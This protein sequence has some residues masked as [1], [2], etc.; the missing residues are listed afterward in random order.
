MIVD[1]GALIGP[2]PYGDLEHTADDLLR[3][4]D[5]VGI[6]QAWVGHLSS[7]LYKE[8]ATANR[9]LA[10][11]LKVHGDR[12]RPVP[13]VHPGL[14]DWERDLRDAQEMG[15]VAVRVYPMHQSLSPD[16]SEM[17]ALVHGAAHVRLP[18]ILTVRFEDVRQRHP[19]DVAADLPPSAVR[20]LARVDAEARLLVCH[21]GR[22]FVQEVHFGLTPEEAAR[23]L[24]DVSWIWGPPEDDLALLL[25]TIGSKS[26]AFGTGA[27]LRIPES[28]VAK[29]DLADLSTG[30][31]AAIEHDNVVRWSGA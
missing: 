16:G 11:A 28:T 12:L 22:D 3:G 1:V 31:R 29:L 6:D 19:L 26:F 27:P 5:R 9:R 4:M 24:W 15:A 8:P 23:V 14:P 7:F 20:A 2:Y 25:E 21:A 10:A 18:V 30:D 17:I 13:T